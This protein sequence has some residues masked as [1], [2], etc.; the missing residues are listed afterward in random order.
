MN[1]YKGEPIEDVH[2]VSA[3]AT[4]LKMARFRPRTLDSDE[5]CSRAAKAVVDLF[6]KSGYMVVH[7]RD[8]L[9]RTA[10]QLPNFGGQPYKRCEAC[11]D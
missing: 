3:I 5:V 2:L 1:F 4:A 11:D 6:Q 9:T 7:A 10:D 8:K